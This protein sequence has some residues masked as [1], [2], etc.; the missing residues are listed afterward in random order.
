M[1]NKDISVKTWNMKSISTD[2]YYCYYLIQSN[3]RFL[4]TKKE[5]E[6]NNIKKGQFYRLHDGNAK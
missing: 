1:K 6:K 2:F 4:L 5:K 3:I